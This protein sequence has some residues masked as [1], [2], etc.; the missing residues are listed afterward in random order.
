[1]TNATLR[2][3]VAL[4]LPA[5]VLATALC[6]LVYLVAQQGL[7]LGAD[8]PQVQIAED[9]AAAL[10]VG[11]GPSSVVRSATVDIASSLAPF[12]VVFDAGGQVLATDGTLDGSD[13]RPPSGVLA[14]AH[15]KGENRVTW[16]PR[17]GVRIA[18]VSVPWSGGTV[19][20]GRSLRETE[21][22]EDVVL[23]LVGAVWAATMIAAAVA[24]L[25]AAWLWPS[26]SRAPD[27]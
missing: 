21:R 12:V 20:A 23:A 7:R 22:L 19:L 13:P 9:A 4:F 1:V 25:V 16:Q 14:A 6:G 24:C 26:R 11:A 17:A 8:Q 15:A 2:R 18:T 10:D 5:A 3:A 27:R